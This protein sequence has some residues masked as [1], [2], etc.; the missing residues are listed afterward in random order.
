[1]QK[2]KVRWFLGGLVT[3]LVFGAV[4]FFRTTCCLPPTPLQETAATSRIPRV[5]KHPPLDAT[6]QTPAKKKVSTSKVAVHSAA[7]LPKSSSVTAPPPLHKAPALAATP[8]PAAPDSPLTATGIVA[9][10]NI[11]RN[12]ADLNTLSVSES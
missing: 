1:M 5:Q 8:S 4:F 10:T 9:F 11:E 3:F 6:V 7:A 12:K 2:S